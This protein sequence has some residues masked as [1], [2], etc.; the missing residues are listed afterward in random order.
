MWSV[1]WECR[2]ERI[3]KKKVENIETDSTKILEKTRNIKGT[4]EMNAEKYVKNIVSRIKCS[5]VKKK[6][7]ETQ[8]LSDISMRIE[9]GEAL[10]Q[11]MESMGTAQEIADAFM[12]DMPKAERKAYRK[13][14]IGI[15][16]AVIVACVLLLG[17]YVWW[18]VPKPLNILADGSLTKEEINNQVETVVTLLNANDFDALREISIDEMQSALT[19]ES[20][21]KAKSMVSG[22]WGEMQTIGSVYAQG[23]KQ[24][25]KAFIVT[26][27]DVMYENV[28]VIYT[29]TFD[30]ELNLAGIYM[31]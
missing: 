19:Q 1:L 3:C 8:L 27:T 31:R 10:E 25:G 7:I 2:T 5:G 23:M 18:I 24:R 13:K 20:M 12:Q 29:I 16:A 11:I 15:I 6:E 22:D 30:E 28:N 21:A 4:I 14:K 17:V 26:Q 9:Q